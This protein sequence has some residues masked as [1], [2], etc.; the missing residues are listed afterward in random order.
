MIYGCVLQC[1]YGVR[2]AHMP[3]GCSCQSLSLTCYLIRR[4]TVIRS[5][6]DFKSL[7]LVL[8]GYPGDRLPL[9]LRGYPGDRLSYTVGDWG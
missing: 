6:G 7:P 8:R 5:C 2:Q 4:I 9:V 3:C 1:V